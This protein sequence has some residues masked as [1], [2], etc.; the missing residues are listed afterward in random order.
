MNRGDNVT[1]EMCDSGWQS[2]IQ[3][4]GHLRCPVCRSLARTRLIP[5]AIRHFGMTMTNLL[6]I[7]PN[8]SEVMFINSN[9]QPNPYYKMDIN[10]RPHIN[11]VGSILDIPLEDNAVG[12]IILWHVMEHIEDDISAICELYRVM[13]PGGRL[14]VSVPIFPKMNPKTYQ[15]PGVTTTA[16]FL[17]HYGDIDHKRA[18]GLDY[19]ERFQKNGF[20]VSTLNTWEVAPEVR[21]KFGLSDSHVVWCC[22]K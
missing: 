17:E 11:M 13:V 6:H 1:C 9:H 4:G 18:C 3:D 15:V 10:P 19:F 2:W 16:G 8:P 21:E 12:A 5:Y 14:L 7:G 20:R 22:E